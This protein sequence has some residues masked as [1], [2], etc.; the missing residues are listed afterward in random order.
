[1]M[2]AQPTVI[3]CPDVE[4]GKG[5]FVAAQ[6]NEHVSASW[7]LD[8]HGVLADAAQT[9]HRLGLVCQMSPASCGLYRH[10]MC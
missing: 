10:H 4:S 2:T 3:L 5:S 7:I 1:M 8:Q 6:L 9:L